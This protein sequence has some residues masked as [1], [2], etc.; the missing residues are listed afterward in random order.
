MGSPLRTG[1]QKLLLLGFPECHASWVSLPAIHC[2]DLCFGKLRGMAKA[3]P[4]RSSHHR[5]LR[6][7]LDLLSHLLLSA[8][9]FHQLHLCRPN[10][11]SH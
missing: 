6:H 3:Q 10:F 11:A 5:S 9:N 4:K 1:W 2:Q 8:T 7:S